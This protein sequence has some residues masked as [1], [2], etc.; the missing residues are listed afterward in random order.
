[1]QTP[2]GKKREKNVPKSQISPDLTTAMHLGS[3]P[4]PQPQRANGRKQ[5]EGKERRYLVS[6]K[7]RTTDS[8][9]SGT[10]KTSPPLHQTW[11]ESECA[12][13]ILGQN[14]VLT[15]ARQASF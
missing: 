8:Q 9:L 5:K 4:R 15:H 11:A 3:S 7:D 6:L 2:E 13:W 1:M 10:G 14:L 12:A